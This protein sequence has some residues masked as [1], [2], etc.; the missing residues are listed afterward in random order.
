MRITFHML[1]H[2]IMYI[3]DISMMIRLIYSVDK[4]A[5]ISLGTLVPNSRDQ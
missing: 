2:A 3:W 5:V 4:A 1:S